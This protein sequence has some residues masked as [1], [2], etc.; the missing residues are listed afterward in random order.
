M[1]PLIRTVGSILVACVVLA[2]PATAWAQAEDEPFRRG[3]AARG[4]KKWPQV[5]DAMR[6]AIAINR[7][8]STRKVQVRSRLLFGTGTEYLPHYFL[9]EALKNAN[10]CGGAVTEWE[11]SEEQKVV[12]SL[13]EFAAGLR[14]GYTECAAKGVLLRDDYRQQVGAI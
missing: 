9:G 5:V 13:P 7:T 4:D 11:I 2:L 10:D 8:E 6:Q 14:A 3:L 12:L 1:T